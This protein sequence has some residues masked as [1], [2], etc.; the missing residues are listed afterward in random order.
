M[1]AA[2]Y[3]RF[4]GP[5]VLFLE[6]MDIPFPK[7]NE[8][9]I[10]VYSS[11]VN[12]G[13]C[14][15]RSGKPFLARLF[16]GPITPRSKILGST[17]SGKIID[18]GTHV[19]KF[20]VGDEVFASM[21]MSSGSHAEY[22]VL[23]DSDTIAIKPKD[24]THEEAAALVFGP[25]NAKYFLEKAGIAKGQKILII[26][27]SGGVGSYAVQLA[28]FFDTHVTAV[29]ST[30]N[31]EF[32]KGLGADEIIDYKKDDMTEKIEQ[33][34]II[35]DMVSKTPVSKLKQMLTDSGVYI[36]TVANI[37]VIF[38]GLF[39]SKG[40]K[41]ILFDISKSVS[42]DLEFIRDLTVSCKF[43]PLISEVYNFMNIQAAH[44]HVESNIKNGT[45][46]VR[47]KQIH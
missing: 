36:T 40:G 10:E 18:A 24:L 42:S 43:R 3:Y 21:G 13:D 2:R 25:L 45:V 9:V 5:E 33:F 17:I 29:C 37:S 26:G 28:K 4:G 34:D 20:K 8:I 6:N 23:S 19:T 15:L 31:L 16:A 22:I 12:S 32:V 1:K 11:T 30:K 27:A 35:L 39:N 14:H 46:V 47:L 44:E 38:N 41:K 7:S